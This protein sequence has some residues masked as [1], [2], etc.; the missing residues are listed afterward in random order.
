MEKPHTDTYEFAQFKPL[1][2]GLLRVP[3]MLEQRGRRMVPR[4]WLQP[5]DIHVNFT[6]RNGYSAQATWIWTAA[7]CSDHT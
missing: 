2:L 5:R 6:P 4:A 3:T 1:L 7:P